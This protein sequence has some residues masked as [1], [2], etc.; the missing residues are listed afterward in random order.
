[1]ALPSII[2]I[3]VLILVAGV[4]IGSSGFFEVVMSG[5]DVDSK[6][7]LSNAEA[8]AEDALER[9]VRNKL[10][11][12]GGSPSC[13]SY[14]LT[15]TEGTAAITVSGTSPKTIT[16]EGKLKN[17]KRKVQISVSFDSNNKA[18]VTSWQEVTN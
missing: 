8:G 6:T 2:M 18:T 3:S 7:A 9:V 4:G 5:D 11:N 10:C 16:S 1:M 15:F 12:E 14:T 17:I 13:S